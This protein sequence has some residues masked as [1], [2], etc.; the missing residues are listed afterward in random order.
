MV[1]CAEN[2]L[3]HLFQR[4][5]L[6]SSTGRERRR[7]RGRPASLL[8]TSGAITECHRLGAGPSELYFSQF[9]RLEGR[10]QDGSLLAPGEGSLPSLQTATFSL[11]PHMAE[12]GRETGWER[13]LGWW[14]PR[15]PTALWCAR[16]LLW[17]LVCLYM[18]SPLLDPRPSG[19]DWC[20]ILSVPPLPSTQWALGECEQVKQ[21]SALA[22]EEEHCE[23]AM[24]GGGAAP[25]H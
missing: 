9:P 17:V 3:V 18:L 21:W 2:P 23:G 6:Q 11:R 4:L 16:A 13:R 5:N 7:G 25:H 22:C 12:T 20:F 15:S 10:G 8:M 24:T 14:L 1:P 19:A